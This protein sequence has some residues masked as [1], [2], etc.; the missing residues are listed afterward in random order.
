MSTSPRQGHTLERSTITGGPHA[1]RAPSGR[2]AC[3]PGSLRIALVVPPW[4][5]VPP[6]GYG[7]IEWMCHWLAESL[8]ARG[9]EVVVIGAGH[10]SGA[11]R[12][13]ST[14]PLPDPR[15]LGEAM[16]E[17]LHLA[18]AVRA[19][20]GLDVDVVHDHTLVGP[21]LAFGRAVPT[22]VTAHGPVTAEMAEYHRRLGDR[23]RLVAISEAQRRTGPGLPW[24]ATV[25]NGIPVD[26]YPVGRAKEDFALFLGRMSPEKGVHLAIDAARA[27][28]MPLV[29]AAKCNE[30]A[31]RAYFVEHVAP[32]LGPGVDW[33]GEADTARKKDLLARARCLVLPL[34]WEEPFGIV[35]VEALACGTPVVA[36]A[37]GA[38]PEIVVDGESGFLCRT[39]EELPGA[40]A[41][42][43]GIDPQACRAR[44]RA[45]DVA[46]MVAGY[47]SVYTHAALT[48]PL[49]ALPRRPFPRKLEL[50]QRG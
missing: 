44:A 42:A 37:R 38:A 6:P 2:H 5:E 49:R 32:R 15:R 22:V 13:V 3:H 4:F 20:E 7:G 34:Q 27:A 36:L 1:H 17:V 35:M 28:G 46:R 30:P 14:G 48:R 12:F 41:A 47:E 18:S 25:H 19:L 8:V 33:I 29:V 23:I 50:E 16:P 21:L 43:A 31:E 39:A 9:H 45:F 40:L 11:G 24:A 26:D 10:R